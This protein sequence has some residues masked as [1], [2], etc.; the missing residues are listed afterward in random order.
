[1][2][3]LMVALLALLLAGCGGD[4]G[5]GVLTGRS[6]RER[7]GNIPTAVKITTPTTTKPTTTASYPSVAGHG[8][9]WKPVAD[10]GGKLV[11][12]L[13]RSYGKPPVSVLAMNKQV[14]EIGTFAYYSNPDRATYRFGRPG[15][16]FPKPCLLQVGG[17]I[18]R[19]D[20]PGKRYE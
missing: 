2:K 11:V 5:Q 13:N 6:D 1:M 16:S 8:I 12:L 18:Y 19:V 10:S 9:L 17:V 7:D 20:D 4:D 14:I 15:G 3:A